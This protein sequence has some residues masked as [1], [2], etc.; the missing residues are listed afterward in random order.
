MSDSPLVSEDLIIVTPLHFDKQTGFS[1]NKAVSTY[2]VCLITEEVDLLEALIFNVLQAIGLVPP[3]GKYIK[4]YLPANGEG[5]AIV[6]ELL[7]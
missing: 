5:E 2:L 1:K 7:L 3:S 6:S 4:R